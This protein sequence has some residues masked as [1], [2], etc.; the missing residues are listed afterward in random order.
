M[1]VSGNRRQFINSS[2]VSATVETGVNNE[3]CWSGTLNGKIPVFI[4]YQIDNRLVIGSITYLNTKNRLPITL[5]G[6]ISEDNNFR[7]LE[8]DKTGNITGIITGKPGAKT[9]DGVWVSPQT[10]KEFTIKMVPKDTLISSPPI[11][12]DLTQVFGNYHY[13]YGE[14]GYSGDFECSKAGEGKMTF[15]ILSLTNIDRGPNIAEIERDTIS[16]TGDS[17]VYK[18]PGS[19]NCAFKVDFYRNFL[20]IT[21]TDGICEG[22]FGMNATVEGIYLKTK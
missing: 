10:Q 21:Y 9:F 14:R 12:P 4:H 6:T 19:D 11:K 17:F 1:I 3:I 22:Q 16:V 20:Y 15:N 13:R 7:L 2:A 18:V 5:L 8:F